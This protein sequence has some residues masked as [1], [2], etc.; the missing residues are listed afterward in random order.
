[1]SGTRGLAKIRKL[2]FEYQKNNNVEKQCIT[3]CQYFLDCIKANCPDLNPEAVACIVCIIDDDIK[4]IVYMNHV[5]IRCGDK[6]IEPS[7]ELDVIPDTNK[8]HYFTIS[9]LKSNT[10]FRNADKE[11]I[12][13][14]ISNHIYF[15]DVARRIN[16]GKE[17][18]IASSALYKAQAD[19]VEQH[20]CWKAP[21]DFLLE[22]FLLAL[23]GR[24]EG[25]CERS[26]RRGL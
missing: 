22:D 7:Y 12:K 8:Y 10:P 20:A 2:M 23:S 4:A 15:I 16:A 17:V 11:F 26:E 21:K 19:Y 25:R 1:M 3:N 13:Q 24:P 9:D 6:Y 18:V 14:S 5:M